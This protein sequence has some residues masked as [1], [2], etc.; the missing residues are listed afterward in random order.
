MVMSSISTIMNS[1]PLETVSQIKSFFYRLLLGHG[2]LTQQQKKATYTSSKAKRNFICR[3]AL[4]RDNHSQGCRNDN[5]L[6][7]VIGVCVE[8]DGRDIHG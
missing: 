8:R 2:V 6:I 3:K 5:T 1:N 7:N 4:E